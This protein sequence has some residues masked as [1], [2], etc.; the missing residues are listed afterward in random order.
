MRCS[1]TSISDKSDLKVG[2]DM[3][4]REVFI[5]RLDRELLH[6][7]RRREGL[8]CRLDA[9]LGGPDLGKSNQYRRGHY[10]KYDCAPQ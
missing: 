6:R 3:L 1:H 5:R 2:P 7:V 4:S 8:V 9:D 10:L